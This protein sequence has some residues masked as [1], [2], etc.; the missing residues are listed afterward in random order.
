SGR[1]GGAFG[2]LDHH[3]R[4]DMFDVVQWAAAQPWCDGNIGSIGQSYY[5]M[6][7]WLLGAAAPPALKC[8]GAHDGL[9]HLYRAGS[10]PG[11]IPCDFFPGYWWFQNRFINRFPA[12]GPSREQTDDLT[13]MVA[14][15]PTCDDFWRERSA[16]EPL[17]RINIPLLSSGVWAKM[18]LHT[19]GNID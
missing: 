11:G 17:D 16:W 10:Y 7:Q 19:R 18:Q 15:H 6:L 12:E 5:C 14:A 8:I 4:D 1:S 9:A 2:F 13:M 3:D